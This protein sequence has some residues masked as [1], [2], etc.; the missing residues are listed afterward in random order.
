MAFILFTSAPATSR[1]RPAVLPV[2][3]LQEP[4]AL[5]STPPPAAAQQWSNGICMG[6]PPFVL[7]R[8]VLRL[9]KF[10]DQKHPGATALL[11]PKNRPLPVAEQSTTAGSPRPQTCRYVAHSI[12]TNEGLCT[13][14]VFRRAPTTHQL[15]GIS[16]SFYTVQFCVPV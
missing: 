8:G 3:P 11:W 9:Y 6:A 1:V 10:Q 16:H 4:G 13:V 5:S 2:Q 7:A 14:S 12:R 15:R